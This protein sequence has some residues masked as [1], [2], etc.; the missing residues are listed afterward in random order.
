VRKG[1]GGWDEIE[2]PTNRLI[3]SS[4]NNDRQKKKGVRTKH[5]D[6]RQGRG[7]NGYK[8]P[9]GKTKEQREDYSHNKYTLNPQTEEEDKQKMNCIREWGCCVRREMCA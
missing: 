9:A 3:S 2:T 6:S 1:K 8:G 7:K 4:P 5:I